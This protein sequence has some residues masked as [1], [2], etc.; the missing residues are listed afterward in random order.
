M[1]KALALV[2]MLLIAV[3][4]VGCSSQNN[5]NGNG[6]KTDST[7]SA[8]S[9]GSS[10]EDKT[11]NTA[12]MTVDEFNT[13]IKD[14]VDVSHY[15]D[16]SNGS[17]TLCSLS[18]DSQYKPDYQKN[19]DAHLFSDKG[20]TVDSDSNIK[21]GM[22]LS[23]ILSQGW[24]FQYEETYD[25]TLGAHLADGGYYIEKNG[26][27]VRVSSANHEDE[28][29]KYPDTSLNSFELFL[30]SSDYNYAEKSSNAL[31]FDIDGKVNQDSDLKGI[32][33]ALG[34]PSSLLYSRI[35]EDI[36]T[37]KYSYASIKLIYSDAG[38]CDYVFTL[39]C[40]GSKVVVLCLE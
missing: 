25:D 40:D 38:L 11:Q 8:G 4:S 10:S 39:S 3:V 18:L 30:Y 6:E 5:G 24:K 2:L 26:K 13:F 14:Y 7:S 23:E 15:K 20:V 32:I 22:K 12:V 1:K 19:N 29:V 34:E 36:G 17:E 37:S 33:T 16:N 35:G 9:E 27:Q 28:A 31:D 21:I